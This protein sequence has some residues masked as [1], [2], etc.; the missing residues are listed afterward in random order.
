MF[1]EQQISILK[2]FLNDH[3]TLKTGVMMLKIQLYITGIH[4][5]KKTV[6]LN[7]NNISQY[8][9]FYYIFDQIRYEH[10]SCFFHSNQNP[11]N[12]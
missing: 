12:L 6:L 3:V 2:W 1:F 4:F 11:L 7:S 8:Y 5:K 9:Y 10:Q